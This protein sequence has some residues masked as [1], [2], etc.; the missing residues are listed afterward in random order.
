MNVTLLRG[1]TREAR[2]WGAFPQALQTA[3]ESALGESHRGAEIDCIDFPGFGTQNSRSSPASIDAIVRDTRARTKGATPRA[4]VGVSLGGMVGLR[5]ATLFPGDVAALAIVNSS[6]S[7][8]S[9]LWERLSPLAWPSL[10]RAAVART[11]EARE[12]A[13]LGVISQL[14]PEAREALARRFGA[15]ARDRPARLVNSVL[16]LAAG[17]RFRLPDP[18]RCR[19]LVVSSAGDRFVRPACSLKL[20]NYL[21]APHRIHPWAG[22][23]LPVDDPDWLA[24]EIANFLA[25]PRP[26]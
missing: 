15:F 26:S 2:H 10:A 5:W 1:W 4:I 22:H 9:P 12:R 17:A 14:G 3:L 23:E 25:N 16:Q 6:A 8:L 21:G 20:A 7:G 24:R 11:P 19:L 13:V 18:P